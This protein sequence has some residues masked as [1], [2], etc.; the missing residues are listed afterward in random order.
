MTGRTGPFVC[1]AGRH[2]RATKYIASHPC[3]ECRSEA[4]LAETVDALGQLLPELA[5]N[6]ATDIVAEVAKSGDT[7]RRLAAWLV[8][9]SDVLRSGDSDMPAVARRLVL[10]LARRGFPVE[11][12]RC[13]AAGSPSRA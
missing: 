1:P 5:R 11:L 8:S 4:A 7:R 6:E 12:P 3:A 10:D 2:E 13:C 9:G